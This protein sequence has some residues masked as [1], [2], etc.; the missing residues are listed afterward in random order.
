MSAG[1]QLPSGLSLLPSPVLTTPTLTFQYNHTVILSD[2]I[3]I[4]TVYC[5]IAGQMMRVFNF[6][7]GGRGREEEE[8][9]RGLIEEKEDGEMRDMWGGEGEV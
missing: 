5:A 8:G 2:V 1:G 3:A 9:V 4:V 7:S 6:A